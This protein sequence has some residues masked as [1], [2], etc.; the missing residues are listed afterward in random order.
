VVVKSRFLLFACCCRC[1]SQS[2]ARSGV[3]V[4]SVILGSWRLFILY[5]SD[6][7]DVFLD[8]VNRRIS[9]KM[10]VSGLFIDPIRL[11]LLSHLH[12]STPQMP[13]TR[14][15]T[16][17]SH[18]YLS[19][20]RLERRSEFIVWVTRSVTRVHCLRN[21]GIGE[22]WARC[23]GEVL[24]PPFTRVVHSR[25]NRSISRP[26]SKWFQKWGSMRFLFPGVLQVLAPLWNRLCTVRTLKEKC[27]VSFKCSL[28]IVR[29]GPGTCSSSL[30]VPDTT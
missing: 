1:G 18:L 20:L 23:L 7:F 13:R 14:N 17:W 2:A 8:A 19:T 27:S 11:F 30:T 9:M 3:S 24:S 25:R 29:N 6:E 5:I 22:A 21:R 16:S 15:S 4:C 26:I 28:L 12:R 10:M